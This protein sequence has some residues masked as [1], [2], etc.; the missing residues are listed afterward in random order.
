MIGSEKILGVFLMCVGLERIR[1][2]PSMIRVL[3]AGVYLNRMCG[4]LH[5]VVRL[6][7]ALQWG[8]LK[9]SE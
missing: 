8:I 3:Q 7:Q 1:I 9:N 4:I 2:S 6:L 5:V